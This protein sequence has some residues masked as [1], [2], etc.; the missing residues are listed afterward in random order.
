[1]KFRHDVDSTAYSTVFEAFRANDE[2]ALYDAMQ[3]LQAQVHDMRA[4]IRELE[5]FLDSS[6]RTYQDLAKLLKQWGRFTRPTIDSDAKKV[7]FDT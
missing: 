5:L 3:V 1:M 6:N 4:T 2:K 7:E